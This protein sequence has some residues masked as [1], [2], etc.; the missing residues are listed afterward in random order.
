MICVK[1]PVHRLNGLVGPE[2]D[3]IT[4]RKLVVGTVGYDEYHY[5]VCMKI[6]PDEFVSVA[7]VE[8][9]RSSHDVLALLVSFSCFPA[10]FVL[11][12]PLVF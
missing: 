3:E 12:V 1:T 4:C 5:H 9:L 7:H 2:N 8:R 10:V 6:V 11:S